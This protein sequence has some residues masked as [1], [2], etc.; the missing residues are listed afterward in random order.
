MVVVSLQQS[1]D[2]MTRVLFCGFTIP[3]KKK[4]SMI[5]SVGFRTSARRFYATNCLKSGMEFS[6]LFGARIDHVGKH[7]PKMMVN[8]LVHANKHKTSLSK[9]SK[10]NIKTASAIG[11]S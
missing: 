4:N 9:L 7:V 11:F 8:P 5:M 10:E 6:A 1:P 3:E 2:K